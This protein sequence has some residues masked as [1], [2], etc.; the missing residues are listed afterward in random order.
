LFN[1]I[2]SFGQDKVVV[3]DI[4]SNQYTGSVL[5]NKTNSELYLKLSS[6]TDSNIYKLRFAPEN[7]KGVASNLELYRP[8]I[9]DVSKYLVETSSN[10]N[11]YAYAKI[12]ASKDTLKENIHYISRIGYPYLIPSNGN[13]I[14]TSD[15]YF[16]VDTTGDLKIFYKSSIDSAEALLFNNKGVNKPIIDY[17]DDEFR[18]FSYDIKNGKISLSFGFEIDTDELKAIVDSAYSAGLKYD[19]TKEESYD[20]YVYDTQKQLL[21]PDIIDAD[22]PYNWVLFDDVY[23]CQIINNREIYANGVESEIDKLREDVSKYPTLTL[24]KEHI[25]ELEKHLKNIEE[26]NLVFYSHQITKINKKGEFSK[27]KKRWTRLDDDP[28]LDKTNVKFYIEG[29]LSPYNDSLFYINNLTDHVFNGFKSDNNEFV[30]TGSSEPQDPQS[31]FQDYVKQSL[32]MSELADLCPNMPNTILSIEKLNQDMIQL[33]RSVTKANLSQKQFQ[34]VSE[35]KKD[36]NGL[37]F[38]E[39][40]VLR[41][42]IPY[43]LNDVK[44]RAVLREFSKKQLSAF[45]TAIKDG[46]VLVNRVKTLNSEINQCK[47]E[48]S[49]AGAGLDKIL[50]TVSKGGLKVTLGAVAI[51]GTKIIESVNASKS[52]LENLN[53]VLDSYDKTK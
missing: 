27:V 50:S 9:E 10:V 48:S 46:V 17:D 28:F 8:F 20:I 30:A 38:T 45:L 21:H 35:E 51:R 39:V 37:T 43:D 40:K 29:G 31:R 44:I 1:T 23:S 12:I 49:G 13:F 16:K 52:E 47:Q 25:I 42:C 34:F 22:N 6:C 14:Q 15:G 33:E 32:G 5:V 4:S 3:N 18:A 24:T 53:K 36:A 26:T 41:N 2:P 11:N 7:S 19:G